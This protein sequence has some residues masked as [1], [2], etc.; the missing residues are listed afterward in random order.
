MIKNRGP[1]STIAKKSLICKSIDQKL[2]DIYKRAKQLEADEQAL[3]K[4]RKAASGKNGLET[5]SRLYDENEEVFI[6][7]LPGVVTRLFNPNVS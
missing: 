6:Y 4:F 3:L 5:A 2:R 1:K 7:V